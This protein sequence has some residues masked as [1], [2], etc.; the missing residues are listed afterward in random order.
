MAVSVLIAKF[1][2]RQY[3]K[4]AISPNLMLTKVTRY[5]ILYG[6]SQAVD[7]YTCGISLRWFL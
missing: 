4:G 6:I 2:L 1:K 3:Q 5:I 7:G